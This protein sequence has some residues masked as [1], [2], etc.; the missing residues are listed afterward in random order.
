[1]H[2]HDLLCW[3]FGLYHKRQH[4]YI[5]EMPQRPT[6]YYKKFHLTTIKLSGESFLGT[7]LSNIHF[8]CEIENIKSS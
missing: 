8:V 1:M 2:D 4:V 3:P 5:R 6:E 7:N